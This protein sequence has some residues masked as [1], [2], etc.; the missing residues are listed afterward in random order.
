MSTEEQ[1][2]QKPKKKK[3]TIERKITMENMNI[4]EK[5]RKVPQEAQKQIFGGRMN[6]KTDINPM[7]RI[8]T[9]TENFGMCGIGWKAPVK[10]F[11]LENGGNNEVAAFCEIELF[12]KVDGEWSEG[13]TGIG[14]SSFVA[15][16]SKGLYTSDE[17]YKMAYT[18]AISV[19]CK[20][21]G[22]GAD[23]YWDKDSTKYD[24]PKEE[25]QI[26]EDCKNTIT[27]AEGRTAIQIAIGT[28][29]TTALA[30]KNDGKQLC[31]DCFKKWE[32]LEK[33]KKAANDV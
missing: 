12:V 27:D 20:M 31:I 7:W 25:K 23:I 24:K 2:M 17:C 16:E 9:L 28:K 11:W 1:C 21:L 4:Y 18:D 33:I 8:K 15:N 10:R 5:V 6:G 29:K 13:I 22:F 14:G 3:L 30:N 19:S 32:S 26:C